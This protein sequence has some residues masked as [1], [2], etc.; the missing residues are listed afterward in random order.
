MLILSEQTANVGNRC[1]SECGRLISDLLD[2]TEKFKIKGYLIT[3]DIQKAF[4]F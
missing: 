1:I 4:V 2:V 3:I